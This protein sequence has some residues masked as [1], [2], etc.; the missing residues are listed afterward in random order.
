VS[1]YAWRVKASTSGKAF[2]AVDGYGRKMHRLI[3]N[4]SDNRIFVDHI[5]HGTLDNRRHNLRVATFA[6]NMAN[7][8]PWGRH[9]N[10][11]G[12]SKDRNRWRVQVKSENQFVV[13]RSV[14][15]EVEA[16]LI[17]DAYAKA[18]QGDYAYL[19][20]R[21]ESQIPVEYKQLARALMKEAA[22][23]AASKNALSA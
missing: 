3:L 11:K 16:A 17:Y 5:N 1:I 7:R 19:N 10:F 2:Y 8:R 9:S 12:I 13:R 6:Q 15:D 18:F 14:Q 23:K 22:D 21:D 20:Y 4:L